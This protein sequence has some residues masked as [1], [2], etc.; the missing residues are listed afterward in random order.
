MTKKYYI[1]V[2]QYPNLP[3]VDCNFGYGL[4]V[5]IPFILEISETAMFQSMTDTVWGVEGF[6]VKDIIILPT[7]LHPTEASARATLSQCITLQ[8]I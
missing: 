5:K 3:P 7:A 8:S 6:L 4:N 1:P 2:V